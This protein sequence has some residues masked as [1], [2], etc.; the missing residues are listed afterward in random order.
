MLG[1]F[2]RSENVERTPSPAS[3]PVNFAKRIFFEDTRFVRAGA[4]DTP[5]RQRRCE[6]AQV[7]R[8]PRSADSPSA[9][10]NSQEKKT[11]AGHERTDRQVKSA[12]ASFDCTQDIGRVGPSSPVGSRDSRADR[13]WQAH[14]KL[15][16]RFLERATLSEPDRGQLGAIRPI[17]TDRLIDWRQLSLRETTPGCFA[18]L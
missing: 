15:V 14:P 1:G 16:E 12:P 4:M 13:L 18:D 7:D 3:P 11:T 17:F 10:A 6:G 2:L 8:P 5:W 9:I